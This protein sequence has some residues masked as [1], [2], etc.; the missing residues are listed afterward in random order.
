MSQALAA[1]NQIPSPIR[2]GVGVSVAL[3]GTMAIAGAIGGA[4]ITAKRRPY[5]HYAGIGTGVV[6]GGG[7]G[8]LGGNFVMKRATAKA[9]A[10]LE[11]E[12]QRGL[13]EGTAIA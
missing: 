13:P 3:V 9:R 10:E 1:T 12:R 2:I 5:W 4:M 11:A 6:V 8:Y 7:I